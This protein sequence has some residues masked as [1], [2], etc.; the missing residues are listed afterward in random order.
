VKLPALARSPRRLV[1]VD[2]DD[3]AAGRAWHTIRPHAL[4]FG[5]TDW[6]PENQW[7][8]DAD[9]IETGDRR[10]LAMSNIRAWRPMVPPGEGHAD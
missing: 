5:S 7:L 1:Q 8:L 9:D 2:Y 4:Y 6:N 10:D 3:P